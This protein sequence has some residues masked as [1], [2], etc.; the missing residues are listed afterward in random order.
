MT[1]K[2][3]LLVIVLI[4]YHGW[5]KGFL[6]SMIGPIALC[7]S[8]IIAFYQYSTHTNLLFTLLTCIF[9]PFLLGIVLSLV[10]RLGEK[11]LNPK[12]KISP[13]SKMAGSLIS[14]LWITPYIG[15]VLFLIMLIPWAN[16]RLE[17]T[18]NDIQN[19]LTYSL[20]KGFMP[21]TPENITNITKKLKN[22]ETLQKFQAS[23]EFRTIMNDEHIQD[24][25]EDEEI[26]E[27][28]K[29][30]DTSSLMTHPKVQK[31]LQDKDFL[32]KLMILNK[33]IMQDENS[34]ASPKK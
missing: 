34:P 18:Q 15:L 13:F 1:D 23:E 20:L 25:M 10:I 21:I 31:L 27:L 9:G 7:M 17:R 8:G 12:K 5:S 29:N 33:A 24:L 30:N 32:K 22:P 16:P 6:K 3:I 4:A 11:I 26:Q 2:I 14:L 19:S 28:I